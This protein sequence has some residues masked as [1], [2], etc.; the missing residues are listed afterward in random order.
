MKNFLAF[1]GAAILVLLGVGW[2]LG[3]YN[4]TPQQV[5]QGQTRLQVDINQDK[6][7]KDVQQGLQKGA[8][9]VH[10]IIDKNKQPEG[11]PTEK[12][13]PS[14]SDTLPVNQPAKSGTGAPDSSR[15]TIL[16]GWL[17]GKK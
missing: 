4:I 10:E 7:G 5:G 1:V 15:S 6:A 16:D 11:S 8:D 12:S 2:Y 17:S 9:K 3:W 13:T 14:K